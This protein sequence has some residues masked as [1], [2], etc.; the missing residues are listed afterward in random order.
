MKNKKVKACTTK[1]KLLQKYG[2]NA[3]LIAAC[4]VTS[5]HHQYSCPTIVD[6]NKKKLTSLLDLK[7]MHSTEYVLHLSRLNCSLT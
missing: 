6:L 3:T 5:V 7:K 2:S 1:L 4:E